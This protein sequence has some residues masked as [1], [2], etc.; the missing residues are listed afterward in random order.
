VILLTQGRGGL[1]IAV[2]QIQL[3]DVEAF[4][5]LVLAVALGNAL[6]SLLYVAGLALAA[7]HP[8]K[9]AAHDL[10]VGSEVVYRLK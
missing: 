9:R 4:K 6:L 1:S 3:T 8:E 5:G 10:V 7:F 2:Q